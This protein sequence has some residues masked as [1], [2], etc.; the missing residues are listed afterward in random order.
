MVIY[1][2]V[3]YVVLIQ[4]DFGRDDSDLHSILYRCTCLHHAFSYEFSF[5]QNITHDQ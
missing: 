5:K 4:Q 1:K 3:F 2:I